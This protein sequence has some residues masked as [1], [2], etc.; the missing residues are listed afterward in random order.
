M[1]TIVVPFDFST[2]SLEAL[3]TAQ[4]ISV[5]SGAQIVCVTVI[6]SEVDFEKLSE[7][8]KLKYTDLI[9]QKTEAEEI[10]PEYIQQIAPAK[11]PIEQVVKIGVP[12]EQILRE[13]NRSGADMIVMGAYGKGYTEGK[14]IG[15]NLQKILRMADMPVLAVKVAL[16]G[17]DLRKIAF[18]SS[19]QKDAPLAFAKIKP[20]VKAFKASVHQVFINTP[21]NFHTSEKIQEGMKLFQSGN[22]EIV[23]HQHTYSAEEVEKGIVSFCEEEGLHLVALVS[24]DHKLSPA[25]QVGVT[26]TVLFQGELG[27][28]SVK[29]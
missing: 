22:E 14:F 21:G 27:V 13:A 19:F 20:F 26:E 25:Y 9:E 5:K 11:A 12:H 18:A 3:K 29:V 2:Y 7:E 17:N 24:G 6:P 23:F 15:S 1:K 4:K 10:L 16:D 8:A 28:L